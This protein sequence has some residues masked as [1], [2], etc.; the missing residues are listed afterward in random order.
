MGPAPI[1]TTTAAPPPGETDDPDGGADAS[2]GGDDG[3]SDGGEGT[4][5]A[6]NGLGPAP[7]NFTNPAAGRIVG[8][9]PSPT[10]PKTIYIATA[11]GGV[12]KTT[13]GGTTWTP[14]TDNQAT[15]SMGSIALAPSNPSIIYAGTGEASTPNNFDSFPGEGILK[16][17]NAGATWTLEGQTDSM[18]NPLFQRRSVAKIVV[19]PTNPNI[20]YAALADFATGALLGNDG[21]WKSTD[22]GLTWIDTTNSATASIA[23]GDSFIDLVIDPTNNQ[24]LYAAASDPNGNPGNGVYKTTDGG[25]HW[26]VAGN[27]PVGGTNGRISLA[28][29]ST[30]NQVLYAAVGNTSTGA[31]TI[32]QTTNAGT[33]WTALSLSPALNVGTQSFYDL[34]IGVDPTDSSG[35]TFYAAGQAGTDSVIRVVVTPGS[36]PTTVV[37][38]ISSTGVGNFPHSDHHTMAFDANKNM[39]DGSDGGIWKLVSSSPSVTWNDLNGNLEITEFV[40]V[41]LSPT[42]VSVAYGGSQ[43]NGT[44]EY[45]GATVWTSIAGGDGGFT[46]VDQSNPMNVY[47]EYFG[48]SLNRSTT[49]GTAGSFTNIISPILATATATISGGTVTGL[50]ITNGGIGY[51]S[52]PSVTIAAPPSGTTA[53]AT[54]TISGGVV[55]GLTITN[56]GSGYTSAPAVTISGTGGL[57]YVPY[58]LDPSN[59]NALLY[60]TSTLYET[61]NATVGTPVW[62]AI[63]LPGTNGFNTGGAAITAI[64][65]AKSSPN[66][67]YVTT[68]SQVFV[69]TNDGGSWTT[70]S[71]A[72]AT[73]LDDLEVDPLNS[74]TVYA[75]NGQYDQG[76]VFTSTDGGS[77]WTDISS[78][79]PNQPARTLAIDPRTSPE[80]LYLGNQIGVYVSYNLGA[81]WVRFGSGLPSVQ[82]KELDLQLNGGVDIL[83]AGTYGR[84]LFEILANTPLVVTPVTPTNLVEGRQSDNIETATFTDVNAPAGTD[85]AAYYSATIFWGD[86][87]SSAGTITRDAGAVFHV[88]GRTRTRR[89]GRR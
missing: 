45:T 81:S 67:V 47:Q 16:S 42:S 63:G 15:L 79:L 60:G 87:S 57:F 32:Y 12:W 75:M 27:L 84:G 44:E 21:I 43:D 55:T 10:D 39:L 46:R 69:T 66:T 62:T 20:V 9:A 48:I 50:T 53:T 33:A 52:A 35:N 49:G 3:N 59:S 13:D 54:A 17:T 83:G 25:L 40:G 18:G 4:G 1:V 86:G 56:P 61:T 68:G 19:D 8:I 31:A 26:S 41:A 65:I 72:G 23:P 78:N 34:T 64:A 37:Q 6:F 74:S 71:I 30:S 22:G 7:L 28:I 36:P 82:V 11:G 2:D 29:A 85:P 58:V 24:V 5:G 70:S 77:T 38:D 14:L 88:T 76:K 89:K 51:F 80:T 73:G